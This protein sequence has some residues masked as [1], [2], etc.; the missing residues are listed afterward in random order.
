[1]TRSPKWG[2][3]VGG[4]TLFSAAWVVSAGVT[5]KPASTS[6][7]R[8]HHSSGELLE[9]LTAQSRHPPV[10]RV[11][12][13]DAGVATGAQRIPKRILQT[14]HRK[15]GLTP[16]I[17]AVIQAW[18]TMNPEY[19]HELHDAADARKLIAEEFDVSF[20]R[21]HDSLGKYQ[22]KS[23]LWRLCVL[24]LRGGVYVDAD[25]A[26]LSPLRDFLPPD[27]ELPRRRSWLRRSVY[28]SLS[29]SCSRHRAAI[30]DQRR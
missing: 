14:M 1:M 29:M 20:L 5:A 7:C 23:D 26:P 2:S 28:L 6:S 9:V 27:V 12:R 25:V 4:P 8:H 16:R 3:I 22:Q 11:P 30:R 19:E 13:H 18:R 24:F 10:L 17:Q 15:T 21:L